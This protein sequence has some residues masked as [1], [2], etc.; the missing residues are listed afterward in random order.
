MSVRLM[1]QRQHSGAHLPP[2]VHFE[3]VV[4]VLLGEGEVVVGGFEIAT[5]SAV[6]S[7]QT[8]TSAETDQLF[9]RDYEI[10]SVRCVAG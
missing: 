3:S 2:Q 9:R 5:V 6:A 10:T 4:C 8:F 1:E 7:W